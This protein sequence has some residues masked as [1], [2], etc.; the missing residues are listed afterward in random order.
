MND[1]SNGGLQLPTS[2]LDLSTIVMFMFILVAVALASVAQNEFQTVLNLYKARQDQHA[3]Q[4]EGP[5]PLSLSIK[6]ATKGESGFIFESKKIGKK[7]FDNI[8]D[9]LAE[10][11]RIRPEELLVRVDQEI[12]FKFPQA[13]MIS[14]DEMG[15]QLG[16]AY[17][18]E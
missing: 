18:R 3:N 6:V 12:A 15:I 11:K 4:G 10:L 14:A 8:D 1:K 7:E 5:L 2:I 17:T 9:A 16:F 13:V